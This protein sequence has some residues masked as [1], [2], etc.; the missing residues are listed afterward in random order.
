MSFF[1]LLTHLYEEKTPVNGLHVGDL[2]FED[3]Q[4]WRV[5]S[6]LK[7][8]SCLSLKDTAR[9]FS[10]VV[11]I[12]QNFPAM[13]YKIR[14]GLYWNPSSHSLWLLCAALSCQ[15]HSFLVWH[16]EKVQFC[17]R[18]QFWV[19]SFQFVVT[20]YPYSS[21]YH[22]SFQICCVGSPETCC[23]LVWH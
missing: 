11:V 4:L 19:G 6:W 12:S 20:P 8:L 13:S 23:S 21:M 1:F 7:A 22:Q 15:D 5:L 18:V 3:P 16:R 14:H 17:G 2:D 9:L 10:S